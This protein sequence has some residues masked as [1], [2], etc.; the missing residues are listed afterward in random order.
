MSNFVTLRKVHGWWHI[1][2]GERDTGYGFPQAYKDDAIK[3]AKEYA[4][5]WGE[6]YVGIADEQS[7]PKSR[8]DAPGRSLI[9]SNRKG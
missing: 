8:G 9:A 4:K 3:G 7:A 1:F 5:R 6:T 2:S